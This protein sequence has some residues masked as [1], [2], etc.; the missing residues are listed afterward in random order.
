M[1]KN[2]ISNNFSDP[3][4]YLPKLVKRAVKCSYLVHCTWIL[5]R[6]SF[7]NIATTVICSWVCHLQVQ[8]LKWCSYIAKYWLK[9][10]RTKRDSTR[11]LRYPSRYYRRFSTS[12]GNRKHQNRLEAIFAYTSFFGLT[13]HDGLLFLY[14]CIRASIS[15][16]LFWC[17]QYSAFCRYYTSGISGRYCHKYRQKNIVLRDKIYPGMM[18]H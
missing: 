7:E 18:Q 2:K 12:Q 15:L 11:Y 6:L 4:S 17:Q 1:E 16:C 10:Q 8:C 9:Y 14:W 5:G 3:L 13:W